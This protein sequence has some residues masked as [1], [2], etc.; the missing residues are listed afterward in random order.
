MWCRYEVPYRLTPLDM[1]NSWAGS[2]KT[3]WCVDQVKV[4]DHTTTAIYGFT[5][6]GTYVQNAPQELWFMASDNLLTERN[7]SK[8]RWKL[9]PDGVCLSSSRLLWFCVALA[10]ADHLQQGMLR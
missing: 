7:A 5:K 3:M 10:L 2:V 8:I 9:F 4:I 6:I 1:H